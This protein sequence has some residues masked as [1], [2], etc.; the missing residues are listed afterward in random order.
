MTCSK[1][2]KTSTTPASPRV[3]RRVA[4]LLRQ[5]VHREA[6][7]GRLNTLRQSSPVDHLGKEA[8]MSPAGKEVE[9]Q[10]G[11]G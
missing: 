11:K 5:P 1:S 8:S 6:G 10:G 7:V 9:M 3:T 2:Y 4:H